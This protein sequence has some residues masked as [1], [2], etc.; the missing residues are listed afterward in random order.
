MGK[1]KKYEAVRQYIVNR[2]HSGVFAPGDRIP[3]E[4]ELMEMFTVSRNPVRKALSILFKEGY[5]DK[6]H[7]S[8]CYVLEQVLSEEININVIMFHNRY[9]ESRII[10]GMRKAIDNCSFKNINLILKRPG[11]SATE[12]G[13]V[14]ESIQYKEKCGVLCIPLIDRKLSFN[15]LL[16][17]SFRKLGKSAIPM[18]QVDQFLPDYSGSC[19]MTDHKKGAADMIR[20]IIQNGHRTIAVFHETFVQPSLELRIEGVEQAVGET[21]EKNVKLVYLS[22]DSDDVKNEGEKILEK[23]K[24]D[25]VTAIFCLTCEL[26]YELYHFLST[27]GV[28]IPG[29]YSLCSFDDHS[30]LAEGVENDITAVIQPFENIGYYSVN[31][32]L[33]QI[34]GRISGQVKM[35]LEPEILKRKSLELIAGKGN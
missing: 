23:L 22:V 5:I 18:V 10:Q 12:Y 7:G 4:V 30:F 35:L 29:D 16:E 24:E 8:G 33:D 25:R 3:T 28:N 2:I 34:L 19:I 32:L 11:R 26:T 1:L 13:E 17:S 21:A 6:V 9:L 27:G 31:I 14:L 20:L 15:K